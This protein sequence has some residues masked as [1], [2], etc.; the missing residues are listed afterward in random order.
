MILPIV[1]IFLNDTV[2]VVVVLLE[3]K[4]VEIVFLHHFKFNLYRIYIR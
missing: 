1:R 2:L 4:A 3:L